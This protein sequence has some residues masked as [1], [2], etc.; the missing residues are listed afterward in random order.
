MWNYQSL[1]YNWVVIRLDM[2]CAKLI[3]KWRC[4]K[5]HKN[6]QVGNC[7]IPYRGNGVLPCGQT[8]GQTLRLGVGFSGYGAKTPETLIINGLFPLHRHIH[9]NRSW[10]SFCRLY[11]NRL[12]MLLSVCERIKYLEFLSGSFEKELIYFLVTLTAITRS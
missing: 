1:Q 11:T 2:F 10:C 6:F 4:H 12:S 3:K 5:C 9:W 7:Q 8:E